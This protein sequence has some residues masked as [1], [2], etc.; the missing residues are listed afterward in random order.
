MTIINSNIGSDEFALVNDLLK[1]YNDKKVC[2]YNW[3]N[4]KGFYV[5]NQKHKMNLYC[6]KCSKFA[7]SSDIKLKRERDGKCNPYSYCIDCSFK[8]SDTID[9]V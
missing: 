7:N 1:K 6:I 9:E 5:K 8:K 4:K 2:K 3:Y